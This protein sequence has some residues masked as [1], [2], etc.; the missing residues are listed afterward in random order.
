MKHVH[1][2]MCQGRGETHFKKK[3]DYK[4]ILLIAAKKQSEPSSQQ[5]P[6][7]LEREEETF[8]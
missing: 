5:K 7:T 2:R 6:K 1:A 8:S 3:W 4:L